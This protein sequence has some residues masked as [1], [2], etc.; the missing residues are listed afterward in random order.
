MAGS[1]EFKV[2][3][4]KHA[5]VASCKHAEDAAMLAGNYGDGATVKL[6]HREILWEE[7]KED[8]PAGESWD[9]AA[10]V[11]WDRRAAIQDAVLASIAELRGGNPRDS[12]VPGRETS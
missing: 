3:N 7:G 6:N 11:M 12:T 1:P 10:G 9:H 4:T 5:Y 2:Y 8:Q